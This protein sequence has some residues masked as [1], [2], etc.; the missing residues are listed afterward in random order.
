VIGGHNRPIGG[1]EKSSATKMPIH[2]NLY[3]SLAVDPIDFLPGQHILGVRREGENTE[4]DKE[5]Q[6]AFHV[7]P[8]PE[9]YDSMPNIACFNCKL[10]WD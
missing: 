6:G 9:V 4:T 3:N 1:S 2:I 5:N 7:S 8:L 10:N